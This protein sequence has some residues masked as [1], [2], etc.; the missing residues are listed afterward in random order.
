MDYWALPFTSVGPAAAVVALVGLI[1]EGLTR[2]L[3]VYQRYKVDGRLQREVAILAGIPEGSAGHTATLAQ[4][5]ATVRQYQQEK[6]VDP[7]LDREDRYDS[8][9]RAAVGGAALC[10]IASFWVPAAIRPT[11]LSMAATLIALTYFSHLRILV[12]KS[13]A[14]RCLRKE[15]SRRRRATPAK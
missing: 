15:C 9:W 1:P 11:C 3:E 5:E 14:K 6:E 7:D 8:M 2:G 12:P 10:F 13:I 4:V